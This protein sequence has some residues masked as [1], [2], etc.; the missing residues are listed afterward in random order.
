MYKFRNT[1]SN[2]TVITPIQ[3]TFT[4]DLSFSASIPNTIFLIL[5][6]FYGHK[7]RLNVRMISS[8]V[9]VWIFFMYNTA[10]IKVDTD[11]WQDKFFYITIGSVVIMN[12]GSAI[13]SGGL[14]GMYQFRAT[15]SSPLNTNEILMSSFSSDGEYFSSIFIVRLGISGQFPS[16]YVTAVVSGQALGGVFTAIVDIIT[17]TF[18]TDPRNSAFTFFNIGNGLL[19]LSLIAYVIVSQTAHFKYY[20]SDKPTTAKTS[21]VQMQR[22]EPVFRDVLNKMWLYGFTEWMVRITF[23]HSHLAK[24]YRNSSVSM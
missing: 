11:S 15:G 22:G 2:S 4:S 19:A 14:F 16:E 13:L 1:T 7:I 6:A 17:I 24:W 18:A 10:L 8:L 20:T 23:L 3:A 12:I 21:Q 9:V 5:N